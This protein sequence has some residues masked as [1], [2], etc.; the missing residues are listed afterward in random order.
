[1]HVIMTEK[2]NRST[3]VD[4]MVGYA[5]WLEPNQ[6]TLYLPKPQQAVRQIR[7]HYLMITRQMLTK[8]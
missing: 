2:K 7:G 6:L 1:M 3:L 4:I 8:H 5:S